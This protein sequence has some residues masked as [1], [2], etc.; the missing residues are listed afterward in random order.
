MFEF[1]ERWPNHSC[2]GMDVVHVTAVKL[3]RL[4]MESRINSRNVSKQGESGWRQMAI[5]IQI[6][7]EDFYAFRYIQRKERDRNL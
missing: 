4:K 2:D 6:G 5:L 3:A 1:K 7:V